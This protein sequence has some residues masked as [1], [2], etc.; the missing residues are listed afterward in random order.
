MVDNAFIDVD[1]QNATLGS[2]PKF[3]EEFI[4]DLKNHVMNF[5]AKNKPKKK[6]TEIVCDKNDAVVADIVS[7]ARTPVTDDKK[8]KRTYKRKTA[9]SKMAENLMPEEIALT[10]AVSDELVEENYEQ[11]PTLVV[12][13]QEVVCAKSLKKKEAD[14]AK[15]LKK[16]KQSNNLPMEESK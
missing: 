7:A 10:N 11:D 2:I 14:E 13:T 1:A 16:K 5:K 9:E 8:V 6:S 12:L 15:A 3:V 4:P